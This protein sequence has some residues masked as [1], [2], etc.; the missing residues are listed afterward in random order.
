MNKPSY[1]Q[2]QIKNN[3][4]R[5]RGILLRTPLPEYLIKAYHKSLNQQRV[6]ATVLEEY[7]EEKGYV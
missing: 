1:L 3:V 7:L 2:A 6:Y 4:K 5:S